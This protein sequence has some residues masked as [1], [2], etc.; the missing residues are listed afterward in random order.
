M[1]TIADILP[2]FETER[3]TLRQMNLNDV[4]DIQKLFGNEEV[5]EFH[6]LDLFTKKNHAEE[7]IKRVQNKFE[8]KVAIRWGIVL[9]NTNELIGT[10]GFNSFDFESSCSVIGYDLS[11]DFWGK[12]VMSE[13]LQFIIKY[14]FNELKLHRIE[15]LVIKGN[16]NSVKLLNKLNFIEEGTLRDYGFWK[17]KYWNL[18]IFSLLN[19]E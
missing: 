14:G 1:I 4:N 12:G 13:A 2:T 6:N 18:R 9:K 11:K 17:K 5:M 10:C 15:A 3:L 16:E 8:M 7:F 19:T